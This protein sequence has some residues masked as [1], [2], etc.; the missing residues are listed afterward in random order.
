MAGG[1]CRAHDE[2]LI[3]MLAASIGRV[4]SDDQ[5]TCR[6]MQLCLRRSECP[7]SLQ[8]PREMVRSCLE[9]FPINLALLSVAK[10]RMSSSDT[11]RFVPQGSGGVRNI[12]FPNPFMRRI[13]AH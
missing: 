12:A 2:P 7:S 6:K 3:I 11:F 1:N 13:S 9:R 10:R 5:I 8:N 4:R